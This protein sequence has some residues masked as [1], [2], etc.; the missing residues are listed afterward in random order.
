MLML[1]RRQLCFQEYLQQR[2]LEIFVPGALALWKVSQQRECVSPSSPAPAPPPLKGW[3]MADDYEYG[4]STNRD[5]EW[6]LEPLQDLQYERKV[7]HE[8]T[9]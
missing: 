9:L 3:I 2:S 8:I 4:K 7:D 1:P 5:W 6:S